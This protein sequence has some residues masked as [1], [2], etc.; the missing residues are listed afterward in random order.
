MEPFNPLEKRR[1]K[2]GFL[3]QLEPANTALDLATRSGLPACCCCHRLPP[4]KERLRDQDE[5][6]GAT[7]PLRLLEDHGRV[8]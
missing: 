7:F 3:I 4:A 5:L 6:A 8:I 2:L 1:A